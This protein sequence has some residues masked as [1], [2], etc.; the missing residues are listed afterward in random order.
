MSNIDDLKKMLNKRAQ[1]AYRMDENDPSTVSD[2]I[3]TGSRWLDN[4]IKQGQRAG[5][6]VGKIC[7][8]AGLEA[9]VSDDTLIEVEV[10]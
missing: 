10:D 3:P 6:P 1:V 4:I 5:I 8:V 2:W 9:C 7:E